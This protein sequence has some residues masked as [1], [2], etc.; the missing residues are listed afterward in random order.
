[1]LGPGTKFQHEYDYGSTT[2]LKLRVV[3][4]RERRVKNPEI[5]SL[6]RNEPPP[7]ECAKCG[8]PATQIQATG[9]GLDMDSVFCGDCVGDEEE[10]G[11]LPLVNSPRTG[12][13]GYCG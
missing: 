12:V 8:K 9:W 4:F 13:C 1:M 10:E 2:E 7:W 6:A 5:T 3:E 11:Y